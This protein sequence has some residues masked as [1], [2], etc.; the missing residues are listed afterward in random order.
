M[1]FSDYQAKAETYMIKN[2]DPVIDTPLMKSTILALGIAG[3]AGEVTDKWKKI[4]AYH[5]GVVN[6]EDKAEL[7][8]E[9]G[10]T[11]WYLATFAESIGL[12]LDDIAQQNLAKLADRKQR[13]V[14]RG[15]G[16]NR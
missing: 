9:I 16:D 14:V 10:D 15:V 13:N 11:L 7:A 5:Q 8:K 1:Q 12:S 2:D 3:E 6:E 4:L